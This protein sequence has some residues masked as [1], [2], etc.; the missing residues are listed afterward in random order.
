MLYIICIFMLVVVAIV[1]VS[2]KKSKSQ[3]AVPVVYCRS[4]AAQNNV[5]AKFCANCGASLLAKKVTPAKQE[6]YDFRHVK[7][8]NNVSLYSTVNDPLNHVFYSYIH[9]AFPDCKIET[10]IPASRLFPEA[11]P[12]AM[13][14]NFLISRGEKR[15]AILLL[16]RSKARRYAFLETN[17]LCQENDLQVL[18][19]CFEYENEESYV[20]ERIAKALE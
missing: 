18:R 6:V 4:C 7:D 19:F 20:V 3:A 9:Q 17:Q 12:Y 13:P 15:L 10:K 14:I 2:L 11:P 1:L 5:S 8:I 16:H